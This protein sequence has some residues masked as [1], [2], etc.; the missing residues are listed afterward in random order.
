[1]LNWSWKIFKTCI[2]HCVCFF[3]SFCFVWCIC[4]RSVI[5]KKSNMIMSNIEI[6]SILKTFLS[7]ISR[8]FYE[9]KIKCK[10]IAFI[11]IS[12]SSM[13]SSVEINFSIMATK[14][15]FHGI[16]NTSLKKKNAPDLMKDLSQLRNAQFFTFKILVKCFFF[17]FLI[18]S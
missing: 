17:H 2:F 4:L 15:F 6:V 9:E 1:M 13:L 3:S 16:L 12:T 10:N 18:W 11:F 14:N 8:K 5:D 7:W